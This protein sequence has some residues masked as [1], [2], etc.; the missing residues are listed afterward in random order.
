MYESR[1]FDAQLFSQWGRIEWWSPPPAAPA[2]PTGSSGEPRLEF[3][4]RSG[5]TEDPGK[6]WS[7]W[8]GPYSQSGA[9][10]GAPAARFA[11]WKAVIHDG[12]PGDGIEWVSLAYLP[13]NVPPVID[14]I[15][16]QDANVRVQGS[17]PMQG[18][19]PVSV[20]LKMP[21]AA[22]VTGVVISQSVSSQKFEQPPQGFAQRGYQSVLWTAHDDNDDELRFGL[23]YRAENETQWK[24]LKEKLDQKFYSLDATALPDGAYYLRIVAT[25][26]PSNPPGVTL[27]TT[28]DSERFVIDN[29]PPVIEKLEVSAGTRCGRNC[30]E[31]MAVTFVARDA[32]SSIER[33]QYSVDGGDWILVA[34]AGNI[35]DALEERY[36]FSLAGLAPGEHTVA[37]RAYDHFDNVGSA[38]TTI[39]ISGA[40]P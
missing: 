26:G 15:A 3:F 32:T 40:K 37:V 24:L 11:Q 5:N 33:A 19:Q 17:N 14:G 39:N 1:S 4:V 13:R 27:S 34:P 25:D 10:V 38:K 12:R 36:E 22:N 35:S 6:E 8:F 28:R 31:A 18:G 9:S 21:P 20:N 2:R 23:F 16:V 29:T 7:R 30:V